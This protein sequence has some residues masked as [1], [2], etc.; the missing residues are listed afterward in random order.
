VHIK[1]AGSSLLG[2]RIPQGACMMIS[3]SDVDN[4]FLSIHVYGLIEEGL[5]RRKH[6]DYNPVILYYICEA[7]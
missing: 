5:C 6:K 2:H 4:L 7:K 3:P 1:E